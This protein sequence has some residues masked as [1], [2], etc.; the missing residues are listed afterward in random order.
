MSAHHHGIILN[1]IFPHGG[2]N[3]VADYALRDMKVK[4]TALAVLTAHANLS[5]HRF[6]KLFGDGKPQSCSLFISVF[7]RVY[8]LE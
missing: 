1:R 4:F 5:A 7:L 8:L 3:L 2:S 6:Y